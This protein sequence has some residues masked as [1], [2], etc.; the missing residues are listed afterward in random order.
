V[1]EPAPSQV[2]EETTSSLSAGVIGALAISE[3]SIPTIQK[4]IWHY[5]YELLETSS[6]KERSV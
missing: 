1:E 3:S 6:L 2:K 5:A 4:K